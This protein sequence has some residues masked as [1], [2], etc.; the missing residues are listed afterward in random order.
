MR[1]S[2]ARSSFNSFLSGAPGP[3]DA[4][5]P[6]SGLPEY[7]VPK[8]DAFLQTQ[9][10]DTVAEVEL[11]EPVD[12]AAPSANAEP[13]LGEPVDA[14][15]SPNG[16]D[17]LSGNGEDPASDFL[18]GPDSGSP[19]ISLGVPKATGAVPGHGGFELLSGEAPDG[20][21]AKLL[22]DGEGSSSMSN[23]ARAPP[24]APEGHDHH[25][26]HPS[27]DHDSPVR[28]RRADRHPHQQGHDQAGSDRNGGR[29]EPAPVGTVILNDVEDKGYHVVPVLG[30]GV[31][32]FGQ[33]YMWGSVFIT[34]CKPAR[35]VAASAV[36]E[37]P[38]P[39]QPAPTATFSGASGQPSMLGT[40]TSASTTAQA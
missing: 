20:D 33:L 31:A 13:S 36:P 39:G 8:L 30:A 14:S 5:P 37:P 7:G 22:A 40:A 27:H 4:L 2:R 32:M 6:A 10:A 29:H 1:A 34:L 26:H 35:S 19:G 28:G 11:G 12:D 18:T 15:P 16:D 24:Q 9:P 17:F 23:P 21:G 3:D 25:A 38:R